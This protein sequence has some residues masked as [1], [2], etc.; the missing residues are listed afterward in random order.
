[1]KTKIFLTLSFVSLWFIFA[2]AGGAVRNKP[3]SADG[4][5]GAQMPHFTPV[6][7]YRDAASPSNRFFPSGWMGDVAD[8]HFNDAYH[9][10]SHSG[11][12]SIRIEYRPQGHMRW[13]GIYWQ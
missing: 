12:T 11:M 1:M 3:V 2:C 9:G 5:V 10:D 13:A 8:I 6:F 4:E 7:V